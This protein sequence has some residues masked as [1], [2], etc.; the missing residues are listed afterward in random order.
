MN[1]SLSGAVVAFVAISFA[2][3]AEGTVITWTTAEGGNGDSFEAISTQPNTISWTQAEA[4]AQALG[5]HLATITSAAENNFVFS[6]IDY[7]QY[8]YELDPDHNYGPWIGGLQ[9][10]QSSNPAINWTWV[11]GE[12][13]VYSDW[14]P[15]E[16]NHYEGLPEYYIEYIAENGEDGGALM[17]PTWNDATN[18]PSDINYPMAYVVEFNP[19]PEPGA[20]ALLAAGIASLGTARLFRVGHRRRAPR[21]R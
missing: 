4:D 9:S 6:L 2:A 16:P 1:P 10:P 8:W 12:P 17:T 14:A 13:F 18:A 11:T 19:V 20:L 21:E 7:P 15:G 3:S 5:G